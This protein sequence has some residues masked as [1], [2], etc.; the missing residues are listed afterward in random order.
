M[1]VLS[2]V[3]R[4]LRDGGRRKG[5][6]APRPIRGRL[7]L[8][9]LEERA[10]LSASG[11]APLPFA[12]NAHAST[13]TLFQQTNLVSDQPGVALNLDPTLVNAWGISAAPSGGAFWVSSNGSGLSEL[14]LGDVNGSPI[15]QPFK[16]TIPGGSPTGQVF[17]IN[18]PLMG[19]G[20][21]ADFSVSD[22]TYTGASVFLFASKTGA[23]TGWNPGVGTPVQTPFGPLSGTAEVGF[24]ATDGAIYTG[25]AAGDVGT[26]HFLYAA[27][28]HNGKIDVLDG[29]FHKVALGVNGFG[30]F[31]DPNLPAGFAPFNVQNL[32]GKLFVTY[33]QQDAARDGGSVAGLGKGF[34]D[35]YD[36]SGHLLQRVASGGMLNAPWGVALAPAGFGSFG[37]DL[38][39]GNFGDGHIDAFDPTHHFAFAGQLRGADGTPVTISGLWGLQFGNGASAGDA[40]TLYFSAGPAHGTHGLFGSLSEAT[41]AS[42]SQFTA[43]DGTLG[44]RVVTSGQSDTVTITEDDTARTTT[45]VA[46]DR[47]EVFDHLF[48]H[49]DLELQSQKDQVTFAVA[50]TEALSGRHLDVLANLGSGEN[51]FTFNPPQA[52]GEPADIFNHSDVNLNVAGHNGNDF[53]AISFDDIAESRVNVNVHGIGGGRMPD[54]PGTVRDSITFG[55]PGEIAGVRNSSVDVNVRLGSGSANFLFNY[56]IDL[57]HFDEDRAPGDPTAFGPSTMNVTITGSDRRQDVD[58]VTLFANGVVDTGSVLNFTTNL[59][60]GN[61]S[62]K[63]VFDASTFRIADDGGTGT[64]G[65]ANF[66]V[67]AGRGNDSISLRSINQDNPIEL[68]GTLAVNILGGLGKDN[69]KVDLGG[70]GFT[71]SAFATATNRAFRLR[72][73]GGSGDD[74]LKVNLANSPTASFDYDVALFGGSGDNDIT[75]IGTNPA[76]G[77]P[78]FG[79]AGAVFIDG[80]GGTVDVFGNFPVEVVNANG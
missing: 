19:T 76:G 16:V 18:Q 43:A 54:A 36:N 9:A 64:G 27:D 59:G 14:Y 49:F 5:P 52:D 11:L 31:T 71:D 12:P 45:V 40:N 68:S 74:T 51:H 65:V 3:T 61:S 29:Q 53:V 34:V 37:G 24:Q 28:F 57:G 13:V 32:G 4:W 60:A 62:F 35:V 10:L 67:Q 55:H 7:G 15:L 2:C 70:A 66:T 33:A 75:F 21:S 73:E 22:G 80:N 41:T 72:F 20:N 6:A 77:T 47:T 17:N 26:A 38:L 39:V 44:L 8:E 42:V 56:G 58:N 25:L 63:G 50:G 69:V 23:I 79:P 78:T 46:D 30:R 1:S 48:A